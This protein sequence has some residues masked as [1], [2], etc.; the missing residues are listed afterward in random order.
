MHTC[1]QRRKSLNENHV[2]FEKARKL[3]VCST[4]LVAKPVE[5]ISLFLSWSRQ[6]GSKPQK[7]FYQ[8]PRPN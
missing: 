3:L 4:A 2:L 7:L 1:R 5:D 8:L 6:R